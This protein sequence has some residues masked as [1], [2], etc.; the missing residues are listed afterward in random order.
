MINILIAKNTQIK[1]I[2]DRGY[3]LPNEENDIL[4]NYSLKKLKKIDLTQSYIK[5][6]D[7]LYVFYI[8]DDEELAK[9]MN[10]FKK[11][12]KKYTKGII[13][14]NE[15]VIKKLQSKKYAMYF[16]PLKTVQLFTF[17]DLQYNVTESILNGKF[18]KIAKSLIVPSIAHIEDLS[19]LFLNDPIVKYY[20]FDAGDIIKITEDADVDLINDKTISYAVVKN[21][22]IDF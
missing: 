1:M 19:I 7:K 14:S 22:Y 4:N 13:I 10:S 16:D 20:G 2:F 9:T 8:E 6:D 17:D 18:E 5:N 12:F 3:T 15:K 11:S 21:E